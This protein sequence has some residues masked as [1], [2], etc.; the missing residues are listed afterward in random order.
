LCGVVLRKWGIDIAVLDAHD[1]EMRI[2]V[3]R[4]TDRVISSIGSD[5]KALGARIRR[6]NERLAAKDYTICVHKNSPTG[7]RCDI[8]G[9]QWLQKYCL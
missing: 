8:A 4:C 3:G 2:F 6:V 1:T 5:V 7:L 9:T